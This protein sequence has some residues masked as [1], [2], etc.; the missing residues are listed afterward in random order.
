[1][2][3]IAQITLYADKK[4][5]QTI[6][7]IF[8]IKFPS[9]SRIRRVQNFLSQQKILI[10]EPGPEPYLRALSSLCNTFKIVMI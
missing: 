3:T 9:S 1:M 10:L 6:H 8:W 5:E 4:V 7:S 2:Y